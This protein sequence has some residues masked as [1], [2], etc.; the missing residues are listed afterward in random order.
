MKPDP[1]YD[2]L[3]HMNSLLMKQLIVALEQ[4][5]ELTNKLKG[6]EK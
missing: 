2:E 4:I 6:T 1:T 5:I 3:K